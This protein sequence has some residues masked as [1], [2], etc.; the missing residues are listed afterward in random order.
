MMAWVRPD[1]LHSRLVLWFKILL[2][3][4]A[5]AILSTLFM[6]S[7]TV[8]PED[9]IPYAQVDIA[10]RV[11]EPRLTSPDFAGMT[12]DGAAL[13]LKAASARV[14]P[15]GSTDPGLISN[16][17]GLLE[18]PDGAH[19]D[20][21]AK[22]AR[23]DMAGRMVFLDGGVTVNTSV[24]YR[25]ETQQIAVSLNKTGLDAGGPIKAT[26]PVGMIDAGSLHLGLVGDGSGN[27]VLVFKK[28]V[29]MVYLP[30]KQGT[31]N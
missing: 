5:L 10:D 17:V 2:P 11:K 29:R 27:Y 4:T 14:G 30:S 21:T 22:Q 28:G 9:A 8:R 26:G 1:N 24:G 7:H 31:G 13:S 15:S 19:T 3:L 20:L 23:L 16:L 6:V 25:I 12:E 18:T